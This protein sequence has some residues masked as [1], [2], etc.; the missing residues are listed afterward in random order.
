MEG[1]SSEKKRIFSKETKHY[2]EKDFM[3]KCVNNCTPHRPKPEDYIACFRS[4]TNSYQEMKN[5]LDSKTK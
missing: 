3:K 4:C 2:F 5:V 1:H